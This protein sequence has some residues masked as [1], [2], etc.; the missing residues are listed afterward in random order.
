MKDGGLKIVGLTGG[1]GSGK[2][3]VSGYFSKRGYA[4]I[5]ADKIAREIV[6]PGSKALGELVSDFG[7]G[8]LEDAGGLNRKKLAGIVFADAGKRERLDQI[9]HGEILRV[10]KERIAGLSESGYDSVILLDIPLLFE[11]G[12]GF[13]EGID[14]IWV[15]DAEPEARIKRIMKRDG[16]SREEILKRIN[17]QMSSGEKRAKAD[18]VIENSG[19]RKELYRQLDELIKKYEQK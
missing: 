17:S 9:T 8:I 11:A 6:A 15:V 10:I 4:V 3:T 2:S 5:D 13:L 14:E 19:G 1:I 18:V 16:S 7:D 12:E